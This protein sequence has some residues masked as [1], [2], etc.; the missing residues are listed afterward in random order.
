M[1]LSSSVRH[2]VM[3]VITKWHDSCEAGVLHKINRP[4]PHGGN[5]QC[6]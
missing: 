3:S 4:V 5:N 6:T 1:S 2:T